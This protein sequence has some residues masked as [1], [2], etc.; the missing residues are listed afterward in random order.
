MSACMLQAWLRIH[1]RQHTAA[2]VVAGGMLGAGGAVGWHAWGQAGMLDALR[3]HHWARAALFLFVGVCF[4]RF[5]L[6]IVKSRA[7]K[8][9]EREQAATAAAATGAKKES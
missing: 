1:H 6:R 9:R 2:Q 3:Q 5:F 8:R 7:R 4:V